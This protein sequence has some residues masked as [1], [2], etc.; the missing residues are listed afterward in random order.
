[1]FEFIC[2]IPNW[3]GWTFVGILAW[4][5]AVMLYLL[6]SILV[7]MWEERHEEEEEEIGA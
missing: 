6:G 2:S 7:Q 4:A 3:L 5:V 1:M